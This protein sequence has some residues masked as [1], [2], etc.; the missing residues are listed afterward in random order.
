MPDWLER[1]LDDIARTDVEERFRALSTGDGPAGRGGGPVAANHFVELLGAVYRTARVD[2]LGTPGSV[3]GA[4]G[5][6]P[7]AT[8]P[9]ARDAAE[10]QKADVEP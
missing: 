10:P 5:K 9:I 3:G 7:A 1:R 8:R 2:Q 4:G 6:P